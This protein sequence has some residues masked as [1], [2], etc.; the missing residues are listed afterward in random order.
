MNQLEKYVEDAKLQVLDKEGN[1]IAEWDIKE[2]YAVSGLKAGETY[3]LHEVEAPEKYIKAENIE[4]TVNDDKN[5]YI[6]MIDI[7][8]DDVDIT[9]YD[10][11]KKRISWCSFRNQRQRWQID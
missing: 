7:K 5:Q 11:T 4:F 6:E 1:I 10:A 3:I 8:T 9:K 2:D